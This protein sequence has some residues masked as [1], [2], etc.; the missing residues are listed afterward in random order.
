MV[1]R[2]YQRQLLVCHHHAYGELQEAPR[3]YVV[4]IKN[5]DKVTIRALQAAVDVAGLGV[6]GV[7]AGNV[8]GAH[9]FAEHPKFIAAAVIEH[10]DVQF[11]FG[12]VQFQRRQHG[13]PHHFHRLVVGRHIDIDGGPV[14]RIL[15]QRH[16]LAVQRPED[17]EKTQQQHDQRVHLGKQ[18]ARCEQVV[19]QSA[20]GNAV[21]Q[22]LGK[23]P[24]HVTATGQY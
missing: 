5:G 6:L 15:R 13:G 23:A 2:L 4:T 11:V 9:L 21:A 19:H 20:I 17:L 1:R 10:V 14:I 12:P 24:V 16:R 8:G 18:Q 7:R 3:R 22:R